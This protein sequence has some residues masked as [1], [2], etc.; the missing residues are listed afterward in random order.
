M[1]EYHRRVAPLPVTVI[2]LEADL[3]GKREVRAVEAIGGVWRIVELDEPVRVLHGP[4]GINACV[5]RHHVARQ[6]K[7]PG[8]TALFQ[9]VESLFTAKITGNDIVEQGVGGGCGLRIAAYLLDPRR[10][11][12]ALPK[13]DQPERCE[14]PTGESVQLL[15][16]YL[17]EAVDLP[18]IFFG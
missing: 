10:G 15:V 12:R 5:V 13:A 8:Q 4:F 6:A 11:G 2:D 14:P 17:V 1:F 3:R 9:V 18:A 16:R 7:P